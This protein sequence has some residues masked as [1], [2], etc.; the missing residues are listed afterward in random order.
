[1]RLCQ[2]CNVFLLFLMPV[3]VVTAI[4]AVVFR[5]ARIQ[6]LSVLQIGM[7]DIFLTS[8]STVRLCEIILVQTVCI[9][10]NEQEPA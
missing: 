2:A 9:R 7:T 1:M 3:S 4:N 6:S 8:I 5:S 10:R